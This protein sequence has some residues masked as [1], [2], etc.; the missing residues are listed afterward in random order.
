MG[1]ERTVKVTKKNNCLVLPRKIINKSNLIILSLFFH[2]QSST[3]FMQRENFF[4]FPIFF[5]YFDKKKY[6]L[7]ANFPYQ[8]VFHFEIHSHFPSFQAGHAC[9]VFN[10]KYNLEV[11]R[12]TGSHSDMRSESISHG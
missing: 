10:Y 9:G 11:I 6:I 3:N 1:W 5:S 2:H 12:E 7:N 4:F 8:V